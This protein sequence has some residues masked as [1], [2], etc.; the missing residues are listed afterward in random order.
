MKHDH[1]SIQD[2]AIR[3][4]LAD[5]CMK[6]RV[7]GASSARQSAAASLVAAA[8]YL[9]EVLGAEKT[10]KIL[11]ATCASIGTGTKGKH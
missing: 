11:L 3:A 6:A 2:C 9:E 5:F 10:K 4:V 1:G 8:A 7:D